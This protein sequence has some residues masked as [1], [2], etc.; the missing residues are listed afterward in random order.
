MKDLQN[1]FDNNVMYFEFFHCKHAYITTK[2]FLLYLNK[3]YY[4]PV[5]K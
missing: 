5:K 1:G 3:Y 2:I 4:S